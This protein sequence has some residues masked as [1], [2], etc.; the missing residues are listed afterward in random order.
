MY[1]LPTKAGTVFLV[2]KVFPRDP[3]AS[4]RL[5][6]LQALQT[7]YELVT[8]KPDEPEKQRATI[9]TGQYDEPAHRQ[10]RA[11]GPRTE[12]QITGKDPATVGGMAG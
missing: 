2:S 8:P 11:N 3:A 6:P 5:A 4:G 9:N 1:K 12:C 7:H 10:H